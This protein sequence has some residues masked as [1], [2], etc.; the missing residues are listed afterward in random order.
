MN[1]RPPQASGLRLDVRPGTP[2]PSS[3]QRWGSRSNALAAWL[4]SEWQR[5]QAQ[6]H[7]DLPATSV[8]SGEH[9]APPLVPPTPAT[10]E[11]R[12]AA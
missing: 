1:A 6:A 10:K 5:E 3:S 2:S 9:A 4:L 7:A 11:A 8:E 12:S